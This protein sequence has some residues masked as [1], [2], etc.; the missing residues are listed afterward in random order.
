MLDV[1]SSQ[2]DASNDPS[3]NIMPLLDVMLLLLIFFLLASVFIRPTL[4]FDLPQAT[5]ND[6]AFGQSV[7]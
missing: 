7:N 6:P 5:Q 3:L 4:D 2:T 1:S